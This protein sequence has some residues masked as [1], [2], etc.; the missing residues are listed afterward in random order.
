MKGGVTKSLP[1][2]EY[3]K[4]GMSTRPYHSGSHREFGEDGSDS[5]HGAKRGEIWRRV[6]PVQGRFGFGSTM[7]LEMS[8]E[9][10]WPGG[11]SRRPQLDKF[12][13]RRFRW[14]RSRHF[15]WTRCCAT[16]TPLFHTHTEPC[17]QRRRENVEKRVGGDAQL[18][19]LARVRMVGEYLKLDFRDREEIVPGTVTA[20]YQAV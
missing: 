14:E 6:M 1:L 8:V 5:G 3:S 7:A 16:R 19:G 20:I 17:R 4:A 11:N 18:A 12:S 13:V 15:R 9:W 2:R 10:D